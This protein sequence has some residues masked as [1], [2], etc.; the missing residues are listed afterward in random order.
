MAI[1]FDLEK[2]KGISTGKN[3]ANGYSMKR[4]EYKAVV[5]CVS[6]SSTGIRKEKMD[7]KMSKME[8]IPDVI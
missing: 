1:E 3:G 8:G 4:L 2:R 6:D 5:L 7:N